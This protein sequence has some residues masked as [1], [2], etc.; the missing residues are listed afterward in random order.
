MRDGERERETEE[1]GKVMKD[2][3]RKGKASYQ[4]VFNDQLREQK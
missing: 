1:R 4:Q 3:E 2:R